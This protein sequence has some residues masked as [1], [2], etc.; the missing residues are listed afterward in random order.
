ME[1]C[2]KVVEFCLKVVGGGGG[3]GAIVS[4][5]GAVA[6]SKGTITTITEPFKSRGRVKLS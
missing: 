2:L 1:F 4:L 3:G 5:A 6:L